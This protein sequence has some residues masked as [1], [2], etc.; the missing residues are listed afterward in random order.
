MKILSLSCLF[1][2]SI[3]IAMEEPRDD[4]P[5]LFKEIDPEEPYDLGFVQ[6]EEGKKYYLTFE[7]AYSTPHEEPIIPCLHRGEP[8]DIA[9]GKQIPK[10]QWELDS[11][12]ELSPI[13]SFGFCIGSMQIVVC[14]KNGKINVYS[15]NSTISSSR[16]RQITQQELYAVIIYD[17]NTVAAWSEDKYYRWNLIHDTVTSQ[18]GTMP[19]NTKNMLLTHS[20]GKHSSEY[21]SESDEAEPSPCE[22]IF[23]FLLRRK[24]KKE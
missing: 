6:A 24:T 11:G 15:L 9:Y 1:V 19:P 16:S 13:T 2:M 5:I 14:R 12:N 18:P 7:P 17:A 10:N 8:Q 20:P 22:K 4:N 3:G 23:N 21:D